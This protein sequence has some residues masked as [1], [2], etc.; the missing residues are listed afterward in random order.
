MSKVVEYG[1]KKVILS[2]LYPFGGKV[3]IPDGKDKTKEVT[4]LTVNELN[5]HDD[6]VI[7][8]QTSKG[9]KMTGY[10]AIAVSTGIEYDEALK[11]ANKDSERLTDFIAGF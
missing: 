9:D 2:R 11:L 5:G 10:V 6:E 8:K 4:E 1:S 3:E 7:T